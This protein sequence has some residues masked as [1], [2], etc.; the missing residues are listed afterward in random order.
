MIK[1]TALPLQKGFHRI[2]SGTGITADVVHCDAAGDLIVTWL[3]D[4]IST[5]SFAA[6]DDRDLKSVKSVEISTGTFSFAREIV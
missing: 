2:T 6:G 3:D 1:G 4:T 5:E